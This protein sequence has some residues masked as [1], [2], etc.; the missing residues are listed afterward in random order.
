MFIN[1]QISESISFMIAGG[2]IIGIFY[3]PF[4][5]H[6]YNSLDV[7]IIPE[8]N[9]VLSDF[10]ERRKKKELMLEKDTRFPLDWFEYMDKKG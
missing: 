10:E 4:G 8:N 7:N 1:V 2:V 6:I 5:I 3:L 9:D